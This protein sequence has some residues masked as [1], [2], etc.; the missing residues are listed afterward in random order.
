MD[1]TNV[2][3]ENLS[4]IARVHLAAFP[5]SAI[6]LLGE[7]AARRYYHWLLAGPHD[8][9]AV[10]AVDGQDLSGFLF[11]GTFRGAMTGFL[12]KN[13][14]YLI[15]RLLSRPWLVANPVV[16]DRLGLA[17]RLLRKRQ[18]RQVTPGAHS[19]QKSF[20]I[21][22]IAVDPGCQKKGV[23]R[24]L[25]DTAEK[26]ALAQGYQQMHL[27]V[28]TENHN[29]IAFYERLGWQKEPDAGWNG[30]MFKSLS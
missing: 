7:E 13:R 5:D 25:M 22:A 6:T 30:F 16:L 8:C 19:L 24:L 29:A 20:S 1:I 14:G 11:G 4:E 10:C 18:A 27:S 12:K 15:F 17:D 26:T 23:G 3:A 2:S 21:L 9:L 28:A